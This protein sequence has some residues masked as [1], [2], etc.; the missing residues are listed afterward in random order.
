MSG[1]CYCYCYCYLYCYY[2]C[3]CYCYDRDYDWDDFNADAP[4][5][6]QGPKEVQNRGTSFDPPCPAH[7]GFQHGRSKSAARPRGSAEPGH[8]SALLRAQ[9]ISTQTPRICS[10]APGKRRIGALPLKLPAPH[11]KG[12]RADSPNLQ[13][14]PGEEQNRGTSFENPDSSL[15]SLT[16]LSK[17]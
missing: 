6:Q 9:R 14:G 12:F 16:L 17:S 15:H 4:N 3:Y 2:Y 5:R 7:Q 10:N 1:Y 13:Q 8:P 11:P